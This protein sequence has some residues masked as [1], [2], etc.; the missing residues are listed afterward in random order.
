M[1]F[2]RPWLAATS[3]AALLTLGPMVGPPTEGQVA[4]PQQ[5]SGAIT[6]AK[7]REEVDEI[8]K[9]LREARLIAA[10]VGDKATRDKLD[11]ILGQAEARARNLS[12][13]LARAKSAPMAPAVLTAA[14]IDKLVN[15]LSKEPFDPGKLTYLENFGAS[16][17][18]TCQ[19]AAR[20]LKGFTF[21]EGRIKAAA[22]LYPKL[23]DRQNFNEVLD[24]FVFD[25]NKAAARKA[26]GLK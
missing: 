5:K 8:V 19:Q 20:L 22:L 16:N 11:L 3:L 21:D 10:R 25:T 1:N 4:P 13:D 24:T 23:V 26:V 17:P 12:D 18:L 2:A 9:D 15:G 7:A 6:P 14:D